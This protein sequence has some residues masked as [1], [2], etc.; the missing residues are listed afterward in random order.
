[1]IESTELQH[2]NLP[3]WSLL[4]G[5]LH[6]LGQRLGLVRQGGGSLRM[7]LAIGGSLWLVAA[8][9]ALAEGQDLWSVDLLGAHAR[10][11]LAIPLMFACEAMFDARVRQFVREMA[12]SNVVPVDQLPALHATIDR[13]R[14]WGAS[15]WPEIVCLFGAI[16]LAWAVPLLQLPGTALLARS[17]GELT[18]SGW[19][20]T[21][22]CL[23]ILRFLALRW[24][25][26]GLQWL[27]CLWRLSR[28]PLQ[29]VPSHPDGMAGLGN[30]EL[31]HF[32]LVPLLLATS[33]ILASSFAV[34]IA[35]G[36]MALEAVYPA[37]VAVVLVDLLLFVAPLLLFSGQLWA[38]RVRGLGRYMVLG[39]QYVAAFE[40]KWL[41]RGATREGLLG[42]P[43][44]STLADLGAVIAVVRNMRSLPISPRTLTQM[45]AAALLPMV[46][47]ILFKYPLVELIVEV[48]KRIGGF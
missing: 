13:I 35:A 12:S 10:L 23:T 48:F 20:Y 1:M 46:P 2:R 29:L 3:P 40:R 14:R 11:L 6:R 7:G 34:D 30:L 36:R 31:V 28:M 32:H 24:L 17:D 39:E 38:C 21:V 44:V 22:V 42:N 5:P 37:I 43:D 27:Y 33:V 26:R 15:W 4:D 25:W 8:A 18:L 41:S 9:L 45:L 19:W 16:A 47:L